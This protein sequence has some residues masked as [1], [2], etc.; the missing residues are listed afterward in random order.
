M[1]FTENFDFFSFVSDFHYFSNVKNKN[2]LTYVKIMRIL[3]KN[4]QN[5]KS[6]VKTLR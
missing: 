4:S 6:V 2:L 1:L 5:A 3:E